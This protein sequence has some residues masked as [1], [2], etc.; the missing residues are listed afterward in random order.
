M[1]N[2]HELDKA[3]SGE[4]SEQQPPIMASFINIQ[5][6]DGPIKENGVNGC[7]IDDIVQYCRDKIEHFNTMENRKFSCRE[8]AMAI[9]KLDE[10]LMW[11]QRRNENRVADDTE[12]T[13]QA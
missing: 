12:G 6:Q 7:Q 2:E 3:A 11:L 9:T 13:S 4:D 8:N 1:S 10:A 5:L